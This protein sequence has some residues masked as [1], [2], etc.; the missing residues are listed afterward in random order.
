MK[1]K[2]IIFDFIGVL[3]MAAD[4]YTSTLMAD[5][6]D[7]KIG[8]VIDDEQFKSETIIK[9][10]LNEQEFDQILK[11]IAGKY[12]AYEPIWNL[13]PELKSKYKL[14][15]INN[16]TALTLPLFKTR[17][18]VDK[19]FDLFVSSAM[20]GMRKPDKEI[21]RLA[22]MRLGVALE[23][24]IFMDDSSLNTE[25]AVELGM[26]TIVW[27]NHEIGFKKFIQLLEKEE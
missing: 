14:A 7:R 20:E 18:P 1:H 12:I 27:E 26:T 21:Y 17:F 11:V 3:L 19:Y 10:N 8:K 6:I 25:A 24:C 2:G 23:D 13:L 9:Y 5:E 16:G 4:S 15:I 22:A